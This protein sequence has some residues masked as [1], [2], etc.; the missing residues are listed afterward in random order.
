MINSTNLEKLTNYDKFL[1]SKTEYAEKLA[2]KTTDKFT[3]EKKNTDYEAYLLNELKRTT[4]PTA[5]IMREEEF[6]VRCAA[7]PMPKA[8]EKKA[9]FEFTKYGKIILAIYV[10]F[11]LLLAF[12]VIGGSTTDIASKEMAGASKITETSITE[13]ETIDAMTISEESGESTN[14]FDKLCDWL[15][16]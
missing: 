11:V 5:P 8:K 7:T 9:N 2:V 6:L 4:P 14:W 1:L 12:I 10:I 15:S 16:N 3:Q 13:Q